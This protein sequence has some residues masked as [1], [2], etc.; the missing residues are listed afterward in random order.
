MCVFKHPLRPVVKL[1]YWHRNGLAPS[2]TVAMCV[3]KLA[4]SQQLIDY[5][6]PKDDQSVLYV[7]RNCK[8]NVN[9]ILMQEIVLKD[10]SKWPSEAMATGYNFG[11]EDRI[12]KLYGEA[13]LI[14]QKSKSKKFNCPTCMKIYAEEE[15]LVK[16]LPIHTKDQPLNNCPV[17]FYYNDYTDE[18]N[19][20]K[21]IHQEQNIIYQCGECQELFD[22]KLAL[23]YHM[24][25]HSTNA[26]FKCG[27]CDFKCISKNDL[28]KHYISAHG[29]YDIIFC[30][31]CSNFATWLKDE[32]TDH[33]QSRHKN[34]EVFSYRCK[35]CHF[36][37]I[38]KCILDRHVQTYHQPKNK[39]EKKT[40]TKKT[41]VK[42]KDKAIKSPKVTETS[43]RKE[44][45]SYT[46]KINSPVKQKRSYVRKTKSPA[47]QTSSPVKQKRSYVRQVKSP[48]KSTK[49]KRINT[50]LSDSDKEESPQMTE[51]SVHRKSDSDSENENLP[52]K[53]KKK[54]SCI[55]CDYTCIAKAT[56]AIH[57]EKHC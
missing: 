38:K 37:S 39:E 49:S 1:Q 51:E 52:N 17:C 42:T 19:K 21:R 11:L 28:L 23:L 10:K 50:Y 44:S 35:H 16:H 34:G 43:E 4:L 24:Q 15:Q 48:S 53:K 45:R 54:Y 29:I 5:E 3:R 40:E 57:L 9:K 7:M 56:L 18:M 41:P 14:K 30:A 22:M 33:I 26:D 32:L 36:E 31:Y 8:K 6:T 13:L 47:K 2:C 27:I 12:K 20:H 46:K 55:L 25:R